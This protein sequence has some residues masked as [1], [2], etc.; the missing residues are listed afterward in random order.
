MRARIA[1]LESWARTPDRSART[2]AARRGLLDRFER[3]ADP[4]GT[5]TLAERA[6]RAEMLRKAY[7]T[8]LA[9]LSARAR[10]RRGA[11]ERK[12]TTRPVVGR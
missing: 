12:G 6:R 3:E 1:A 9:Y 10:R 5:L 8:R 4:D 2:A 11:M 7:Y